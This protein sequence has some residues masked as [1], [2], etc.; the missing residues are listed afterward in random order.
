MSSI[1]RRWR[2][3]VIVLAGSTAGLATI[4]ALGLSGIGARAQTA[5]A[6]VSSAAVAEVSTECTAASHEVQ[7]GTTDGFMRWINQQCNS[8]GA[9]GLAA[10]AHNNAAPMGALICQYANAQVQQGTATTLDTTEA[11]SCDHKSPP[12]QPGGIRSLA[13]L[14][15]LGPAITMTNVWV[16]TVNG[17]Q[18]TVYAGSQAQTFKFGGSS[19]TN[20][21][22]GEMVVRD[23]NQIVR[24]HAYPSSG[25]DGALTIQSVNGM[26]LSLSAADGATYSF[27]MTTNTLT[28]TG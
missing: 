6:G 22:Q 10:T 18:E 27:D 26:T 25:L 16:G 28:K 17:V 9:G 24:G 13:N 1:R 23:D 2:L 21:Q 12:P 7:T 14:P 19:P 11:K 8:I 3:G 15:P 4:I 5:P 20:P